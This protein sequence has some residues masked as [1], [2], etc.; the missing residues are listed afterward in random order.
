MNKQIIRRNFINMMDNQF[1]MEFHKKTPRN[2]RIH[3]KK[4]VYN[5]LYLIFLF[6]LIYIVQWY[7]RITNQQQYELMIYISG[8]INSTMS[9]ISKVPVLR[10]HLN[11]FVE[12]QNID[13]SI[14]IEKYALYATNILYHIIQVLKKVRHR[15]DSE[16]G[17]SLWDVVSLIW[18]IQA[19]P[20][21]E[22]DKAMNRVTRRTNFVM[23]LFGFNTRNNRMRKRL[24]EV[25]TAHVGFIMTCLQKLVLEGL[26]TLTSQVTRKNEKKYINLKNYNIKNKLDMNH[27]K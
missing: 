17:K 14:I 23:N 3:I 24:R 11:S 7:K 19:S 12:Q 25:H 6:Y 8:I 2:I 21:S 26:V 5:V 16:L 4:F 20:H 13:K 27:D 10:N 9:T 1:V 22:L 18:S 15:K